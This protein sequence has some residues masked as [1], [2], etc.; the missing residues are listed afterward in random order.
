MF[1]A[2]RLRYFLASVDFFA[3]E[4]VSFEGAQTQKDV[5]HRPHL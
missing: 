5:Q 1:L 3:V 2:R 4:K